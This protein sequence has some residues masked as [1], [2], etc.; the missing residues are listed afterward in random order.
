[1]IEADRQSR[2]TQIRAQLRDA[3]Q[4]GHVQVVRQIIEVERRR[5]AE[6]LSFMDLDANFTAFMNLTP[7]GLAVWDGQPR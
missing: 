6:A 1:V 4:H 3:I 5:K 2:Q 7:L